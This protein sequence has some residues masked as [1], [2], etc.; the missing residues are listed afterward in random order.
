MTKSG[1]YG[2]RDFDYSP[3]TIRESVK[4]SLERLQTD[5]LDVV[6]LHDI[7]FVATEFSPRT[8]GNHTSAL[9][10]DKAAYGL[11]EGDEAKIRGEGDQRVLDAFAELQKLKEEGLIKHIGL[12]GKQISF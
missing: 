11:A 4:K 9:N 6:H 7:E 3:T 5:Y 12:T 10:D 8:T 1:R 2:T